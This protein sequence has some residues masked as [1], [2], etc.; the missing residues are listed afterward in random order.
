[1]AGIYEKIVQAALEAKHKSPWE[2]TDFDA[3][4]NI[5]TPDVCSRFSEECD[6]AAVR[7]WLKALPS[8]DREDLLH[9]LNLPVASGE[10][11]GS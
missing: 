8:E 9:R 1:M 2:I 5:I 11:Q 3:I 6:A 10:A 4:D 7:D